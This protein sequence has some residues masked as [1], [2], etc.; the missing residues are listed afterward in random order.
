M[1]KRF[2]FE[3]TICDQP[4]EELFQKQ[5]A[6]FEKKFPDIRKENVLED[7]DGSLYQTYHHTD[8]DF[9]VSNDYNVGCLYV[10]SDFD[11][12]PYFE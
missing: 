9:I 11:L 10:E 1:A 4:D 6:A 5:C 8:G 7:V 2:N 3:Y 12:I